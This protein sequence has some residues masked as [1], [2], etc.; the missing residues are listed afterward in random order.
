MITVEKD[1]Y[2]G[3]AP[4]AKDFDKLLIKL[5]LRVLS[6]PAVVSFK[7]AHENFEFMIS[8]Q[9]AL[10]QDLM[11]SGPMEGM[12]KAM[13]PRPVDSNYI[14]HLK[15]MLKESVSERTYRFRED[16]YIG[17]RTFDYRFDDEWEIVGENILPQKDGKSW[18]F[19]PRV[20]YEFITSNEFKNHFMNKQLTLPLIGV[21][22]KEYYVVAIVLWCCF[23]IRRSKG[24]LF[25]KVAPLDEKTRRLQFLE[26][27]RKC[28]HYEMYNSQ[29]YTDVGNFMRLFFNTPGIVV[30]QSCKEANDD[31]NKLYKVTM[32]DPNFVKIYGPLKKVKPTGVTLGCR[33][34]S[35][36]HASMVEQDSEHIFCDELCQAEFYDVGLK[37]PGVIRRRLP[38]KKK[39][40]VDEIAITV[41]PPIE[42]TLPT[43]LNGA[44][45]RRLPRLIV[46]MARSLEQ[47]FL[48]D[49][50]IYQYEG[51]TYLH[52][53][54]NFGFTQLLS[55]WLQTTLMFE[56][57]RYD[58][59]IDLIKLVKDG[60]TFIRVAPSDSNDIS[61]PMIL[62]ASPQREITEIFV[63]Y[64]V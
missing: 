63:P 21:P 47:E 23:D 16:N 53:R 48:T 35:S 4:H 36:L 22:M 9:I 20:F 13:L 30:V 26:V 31:C 15:K 11:E 27:Y 54:T 8:Q 57:T 60:E 55:D 37:I 1:P 12:E 58:V 64:T 42:K 24:K 25:V 19:E 40:Q 50:K 6:H 46:S 18:A 49:S 17:G 41:I 32:P 34:C 61:Q 2:V 45:R 33:L 62:K 52:Y 51:Q 59:K 43:V 56:Q 7:N 5:A 44:E 39:Q 28:I 14:Q 10:A 38:S 29:S 3:D